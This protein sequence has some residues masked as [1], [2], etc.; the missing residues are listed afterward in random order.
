MSEKKV[1]KLSPLGERIASLRGEHKHGVVSY[2]LDYSSFRN[3]IGPIEPLGRG[4]FG[5]SV[6]SYAYS[7]DLDIYVW[8]RTSH[9]LLDISTLNS[10]DLLEFK[11]VYNDW[12]FNPAEIGPAD[13]FRSF[14]CFHGDKHGQVA[15]SYREFSCLGF[16]WPRDRRKWCRPNFVEYCVYRELPDS[17]LEESL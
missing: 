8:V 15:K 11:R 2:A 7:P 12:A 17:M 6:I 13:D 16:R 9:Y 5:Y 10:D 4:C 3:D 14:I 1:K